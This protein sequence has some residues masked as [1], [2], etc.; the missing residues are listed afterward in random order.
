MVDFSNDGLFHFSF[1]H[2]EI[3]EV[4]Y[5][6]KFCRLF[7]RDGEME[8][9][10]YL[11]SHVNC[12]DRSDSQLVIEFAVHGDGIEVIRSIH[13]AVFQNLNQLLEYLFF[14]HV[15]FP[16]RLRWP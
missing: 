12:G 16:L 8:S 6:Y 1:A 2:D 14:S 10:L 5:L 15:L 9:V 7:V 11:Q 3:D 4:F 13:H